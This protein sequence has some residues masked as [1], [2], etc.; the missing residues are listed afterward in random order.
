MA[1]LVKKTIL[2]SK[3][4]KRNVHVNM[5]EK[6]WLSRKEMPQITG[7]HFPAFNKYMKDNDVTV[8]NMKIEVG[9]LKP[10][11]SEINNEKVKRFMKSDDKKFL[12]KKV[13]VSSD[14]YLLD[15]H[16][17]WAALLGLDAKNEIECVRFSVP[18]K[19]LL[20]LAHSFDKVE[21]HGINKAIVTGVCQK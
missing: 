15:G 11:Q 2:D 5:S 16:H 8:E 21:Y 13:L 9:K 7:E 18:I 1:K 17:R 19:K 20:K 14:N 3:G 12:Y 10:T 6:G 4:K